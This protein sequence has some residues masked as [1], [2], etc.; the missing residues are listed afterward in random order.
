MALHDQIRDAVKAA[1]GDTSSARIKELESSL[2]AALA[3]HETTRTA[4]TAATAKISALETAAAL[5][6]A[7]DARVTAL[8]A[9]KTTLTASVATLTAEKTALTEKVATLEATI[10]DPNGKIEKVAGTKAAEIA[11]A[12]GIAPIP[13]T[14]AANP[15]TEKTGTDGLKGRARFA[16]ATKAQLDKDFP[17]PG[18]N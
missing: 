12:Q 17:L 5:V 6:P 4:L 2:S 9:E 13:A 14:P 16:A 1:L 18:R 7:T 10:A 15:K 8:E 11:A 3:A